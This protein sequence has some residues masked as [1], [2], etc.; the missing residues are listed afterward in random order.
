MNHNPHDCIQI[1]D[2]EPT[3]GSS[4]NSK[5]AVTEKELMKLVDLIIQKDQILESL[6]NLNIQT[7][8]NIFKDGSIVAFGDESLRPVLCNYS[9][10]GVPFMP[11]K[12][13]Q[14]AK[15][16]LPLKQMRYFDKY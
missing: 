12:N 8:D 15:W 10:D 1:M 6:F 9:L 16:I 14:P 4:K 13:S 2:F 7:E 3:K 11:M 5:K